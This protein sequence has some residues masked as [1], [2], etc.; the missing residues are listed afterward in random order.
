MKRDHYLLYNVIHLILSSMNYIFFIFSV[1]QNKCI[2][3]HN[4]TSSCLTYISSVMSMTYKI[5]CQTIVTYYA[6]NKNTPM[7]YKVHENLYRS[8]FP[9]PVIMINQVLKKRM[10]LREANHRLS[11]IKTFSQIWWASTSIQQQWFLNAHYHTI[12]LSGKQIRLFN[13]LRK[14]GNS[15]FNYTI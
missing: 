8:L 9:F 14:S 15:Q 13:L 7:P 11:S 5:W 4:G 10:G 3:A 1:S 2:L 6:K 12:H